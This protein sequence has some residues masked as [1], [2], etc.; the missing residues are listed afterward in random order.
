MK[1]QLLKLQ[2]ENKYFVA[3]SVEVER[4]IKKV[5]ALQLEYNELTQAHFKTRNDLKTLQINLDRLIKDYGKMEAI[6]VQQEKT[7]LELENTCL[8]LREQLTEINIDMEDCTHELQV[9]IQELKGKLK[10]RKVSQTTY[11]DNQL[12]ESK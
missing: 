4:V 12:K 8:Q 1:T 5:E 7:L 11:M 2:V 3:N 9:H 6:S 10:M